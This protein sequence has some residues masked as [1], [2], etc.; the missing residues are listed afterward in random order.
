MTAAV[1][2]GWAALFAGRNAAHS[3]VLG[4]GVLLQAV[5]IYVAA[6]IMPSV[7]RDIGGLDYYAWSTTLFVVASILGAAVSARLLRR[8]GGRGA[9]AVAALLFGAGSLA[10]AAAPSMAVLL[11]G[12]FVQGLGGGL[13]YALAYGV[14]RLVFPEPLWARAIGLISTLWG[15]ATLIGPA[16]GGVFA[17]AGAWRA[18]FWTLLPATAL[19]AALAWATLPGTAGAR[20]DGARPDGALPAGQLL[21]LSLAVLVLSAGGVGTD[22]SRHAAGILG[23]LALLALLVAVE[24][25]AAVRLLPAGAL[26]AGRA[27]GALYVTVALLMIGMQPEVYVPYLLQVLH[28]QSPLAAGYLAALPAMGWTLGS[29]LGADW[30]GRRAERAVALGPALCLAGLAL[31]AAYLPAGGALVPACAGLLLVGF[32][33]GLC[34]PHLVTRTI[35]AAAA[36]EQDLAA[37]AVTTVQLFAAALGA[38]AAGAAANRAGIATPGGA[39]GA[40]HAAFWLFALF[41]VAPAAAVVTAWRGVRS[42]TGG[43]PGA[44]GV[45][46]SG[47]RK[48]CPPAIRTRPHVRMRR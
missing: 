47:E 44:N 48:S 19:F 34:W 32:G 31:G 26:R 46:R 25:R 38:A 8:S 40:S 10:C 33:I 37:A 17:A 5:N 4:G 13:L 24:R 42:R 7:V 14:V 16:L 30:S 43:S 21:L 29:L 27:P 6:T 28:G 23:A 39:A 12:R 18:A 41:A 36:A 35:R 45:P 2:A 3:L 11:A 22:P 9:Y 20:E 1:P 15:V